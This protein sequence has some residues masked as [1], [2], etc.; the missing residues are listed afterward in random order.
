VIDLPVAGHTFAVED[1]RVALKPLGLSAYQGTTA[2]RNVR[3]KKVA[4]E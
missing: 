1:Q 2:V 3:V 4:A